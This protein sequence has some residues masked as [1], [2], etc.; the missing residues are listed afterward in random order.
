MITMKNVRKT[1]QKLLSS[2]TRLR[3][4]PCIITLNR[5]VRARPT[6]MARE[7]VRHDAVSL[8]RFVESI[9]SFCGTASESPAYLPASK[10][11][12]SSISELGEKT[13]EYLTLFHNRLPSDPT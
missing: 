5:W 12:L 10:A 13:K 6:S 1:Y 7:E 3:R 11:F 4:V 2:C 9:C 8:F